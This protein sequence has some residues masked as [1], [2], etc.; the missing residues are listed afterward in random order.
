MGLLFAFWIASL[1]GFC[2]NA[3]RRILLSLALLLYL[4]FITDFNE[5]KIIL[6][7]NCEEARLIILIIFL[8]RFRFVF[9]VIVSSRHFL[10]MIFIQR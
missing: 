1:V 6:V 5:L 2:A 7:I 8:T 4:V 10:F 3:C 9:L